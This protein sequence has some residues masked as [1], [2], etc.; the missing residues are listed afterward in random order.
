MVEKSA[1][2]HYGESRIT[3]IYKFYVFLRFNINIIPRRKLI[4]SQITFNFIRKWVSVLDF[5]WFLTHGY[6]M[7]RLSQV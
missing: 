5:F 4:S 6:T 3:G 7:N 1:F 2:L